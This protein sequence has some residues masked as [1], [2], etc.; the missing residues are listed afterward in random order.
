M[1][2]RQGSQWE[3][4]MLKSMRSWLSQIMGA[5]LACRGHGP[6]IQETQDSLHNKELSYVYF[7]IVSCTVFQVT[8][9][10]RSATTKMFQYLLQK[11]H[12]VSENRVTSYSAGASMQGSCPFCADSCCVHGVSTEVNA[13]LL[14]YV[15][16]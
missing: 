14:H 9:L 16:M 7:Y 5:P 6:G 3:N 12:A 8:R 10:S 11:L 1:P 2:A 15:L 13:G 4:Y